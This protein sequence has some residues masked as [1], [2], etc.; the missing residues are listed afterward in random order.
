MPWTPLFFK[1]DGKK[2]FILGSGEVA[3]RRA[4][5][6]REAGAKVTICGDNIQPHLKKIG[7]IYKPLEEMEKLIKWADIIV[8]ASGDPTLN[9]KAASL[10]SGKLL[11]R[12]DK[13]QDGNLIVPITFSTDD[14]EIAIST[15]GKSPI[16]ARV[17]RDKIKNL[18]T[19][20]DILQIRLQDYARRKLKKTIQDQKTRRR[21]LYNLSK[22][23][24]IQ[25]HLKN[26][27]LEGAKKYV[28]SLL[29]HVGVS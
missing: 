5:R 13:P 4:I 9:E 17:I 19:E 24:K 16:M 6:F 23:D 27:N 29:E 3:T 10:A 28:D 11:N 26:R 7:I 18:I 8:T 14:V 25:A 21:I 22:D 2:V 15:H 1:L 20:D 12:A